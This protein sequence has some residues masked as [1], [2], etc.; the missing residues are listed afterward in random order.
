MFFLAHQT[1]VLLLEDGVAVEDVLLFEPA[2]GHLGAVGVQPPGG[3]GEGLELLG[4]LFERLAGVPVP[5]RPLVLQRVDLLFCPFANLA[6]AVGRERFD[7]DHVA[8]LEFDPLLDRAVGDVR[9]RVLLVVAQAVTGQVHDRVVAVAVDDVL[10]D[11]PDLAGLDAGFD[12]VEGGVQSFL[13]GVLQFGVPGEVDGDG[14]VGEPAVDADADV[15]VDHVLAERRR[16]VDGGRG[17]GRFLVDADVD[18]EG[19]LGTEVAD[20]VLGPLGDFEVARAD[21]DHLGGFVAHF[22]EYFPR[23]PVFLELLGVQIDVSH[24]PSFGE[25]RQRTCVRGRRPVRCSRPPESTVVVP[26]APETT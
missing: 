7:C 22:G 5:D 1:A 19:G 4:D 24:T 3:E 21:L 15:E 26:S 14:G 16:V 10:D 18:G 2:D 25:G 9:R 8:D 12:D 6:A 11:G 23:L 13:G 20:T 17:V